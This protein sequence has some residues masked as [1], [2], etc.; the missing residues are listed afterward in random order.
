MKTNSRA[1]AGGWAV[2]GGDGVTNIGTEVVRKKTHTHSGLVERVIFTSTFT[3]RV[4]NITI[5]L[6]NAG[7]V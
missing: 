5:N 3:V 2:W 4:A 7:T 1:R 6:V